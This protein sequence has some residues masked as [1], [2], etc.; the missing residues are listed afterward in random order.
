MRFK[1]NN[2]GQSLKE[3][4]TYEII[5]ANNTIR[6]PT[7]CMTASGQGLCPLVSSDTWLLKK[8]E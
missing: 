7:I 3:V 4:A 6:C 2:V 5:S 1:K 8:L